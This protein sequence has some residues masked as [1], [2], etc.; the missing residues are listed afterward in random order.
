MVQN[1]YDCVAVKR[2]M[3]F[4]IDSKY[5]EVK[6]EETNC[7][8]GGQKKTRP[9]VI[10]SCNDVNSR[11][12]LVT[13]APIS[14]GVKG[15]GLKDFVVFKDVDNEDKSIILDQITRIPVDEIG[16]YMYSL[17][18]N[19]MDKV[20]DALLYHFGI[21]SSLEKAE[22]DIKYFVE[23][24]LNNQEDVITQRVSSVVAEK[25]RE[26]SNID[27]SVNRCADTLVGSL[28]EEEMKGLK[29]MIEYQDH[30]K[31]RREQEKKKFKKEGNSEKRKIACKEK[32]FWDDTRMRE[33]LSDFDTMS[34]KE[35]GEKWG[36]DKVKSVYNNKYEFRKR[37]ESGE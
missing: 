36:I 18:T 17:S 9:W 6:C 5:I 29:P 8:I 23:R 7:F 30:L 15:D 16:R 25:L 32:N 2:G 1:N 27:L 26:I 19:V 14:S 24:V 21:K 4:Y 37:V 34:A 20:D 13:I 10:L 12:L 33:F 11:N 3:V 28:S 31:K 22:E 35:V